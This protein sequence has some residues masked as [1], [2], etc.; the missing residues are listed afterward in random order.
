MN[1]NLI[2]YFLLLNFACGQNHRHLPKSSYNDYGFYYNYSFYYGFQRTTTQPPPLLPPLPK[3]CPPGWILYP[4]PF[5]VCIFR[6]PDKVNWDVANAKCRVMV[7]IPAEPRTKA[8]VS[9]IT[10]GRGRNYEKLFL[11]MKAA[12]NC[13][14]TYASHPVDC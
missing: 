10:G 12:S 14:T 8:E 1:K 13:I 5:P 4:S 11:G 3:T 6:S 7:A 2:V 9:F